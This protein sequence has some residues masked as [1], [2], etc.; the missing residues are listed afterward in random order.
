M[1]IETIP[2]LTLVYSY[3]ALTA[4][5]NTQPM[6][7]QE[8]EHF[9]RHIVLNSAEKLKI[10][11]LLNPWTFVSQAMES[12]AQVDKESIL[13][14][15]T[16]F[17]EEKNFRSRLL[18]VLK[19][20]PVED[21]ISHNAEMVFHKALKEFPNYAPVWIYNAFVQTRE[22]PSL[23]AGLLQCAGRL[24]YSLVKDI[25]TSLVMVGLNDPNFEIR[26]AAISAI[27]QWEKKDFLGIL[28]EHEDPIKWLDGYARQV[29]LDLSGGEE[30]ITVEFLA[31]KFTLAKWGD[32]SSQNESKKITTDDV[33]AD[34]IICLRTS[35]NKLSIW[36]CDGREKGNVR[37]VVL[38]MATG[39]SYNTLDKMHII[40]LPKEEIE[41]EGIQLERSPDSGDTEVEEL[42][43]WHFDLIKLTLK[44][45][46][47][48]AI[49][50]LSKI[51]ENK[52]IHLF[53]KAEVREI[54]KT[55]I[56][57]KRLRLEQL[58]EKVRPKVEKALYR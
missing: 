7:E 20:E 24:E 4:E 41:A 47:K 13:S 54:L 16:E 2:F 58:H 29:I 15:Q 55:A 5:K 21:G 56:L 18:S 45:L 49:L 3:T 14:E 6:L 11:N 28:R 26:E 57:N 12:F 35:D 51:Y 19:E 33:P 31:R 23:A 30:K 37:D 36:Q 34:A 39:S 48:I 17:L 27:E 8:G 46:T 43:K 1:T 40:A 50:M 32:V 53:T 44:D 42:K 22:Q 38:A 25:A 10:S 52:G 9:S